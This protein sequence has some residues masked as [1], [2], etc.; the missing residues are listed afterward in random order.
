MWPAGAELSLG[1]GRA[2]GSSQPC[3][4]VPGGHP[5]PV[6]PC[7]S[8]WFLPK[9]QW[10]TEAVGAGSSVPSG[11]RSVAGRCLPVWEPGRGQG[12]V[13]GMPSPGPPSSPCPADLSGGSLGSCTSG[14]FQSTGGSDWR[15]ERQI[16]VFV[17]LRPPQG[18]PGVS[19]ASG[20]KQ[21]VPPIWGVPRCLRAEPTVGSSAG[22]GSQVEGRQVW[23]LRCELSQ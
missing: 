21:M 9:S 17:C 10:E 19:A 2:R 11:L 22:Q 1:G 8:S 15:E 14:Q 4:P 18:S 12:W 20:R 3:S 23:A 7:V 5:K 13:L 6:P 16:G